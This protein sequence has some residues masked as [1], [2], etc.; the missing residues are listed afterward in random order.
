MQA[1]LPFV[2]CVCSY[3]AVGDA[4]LQAVGFSDRLKLG[5]QSFWAG[6]WND[7]PRPLMFVPEHHSPRSE[8]VAALAT[9]G[10]DM[11]ATAAA[12][13]MHAEMVRRTNDTRIRDTSMIGF[14]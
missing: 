12:A 1:P 4:P 2:V 13:I 14:A 10:T 11:A 3:V 7:E 5:F 9:P 8:F 6:A